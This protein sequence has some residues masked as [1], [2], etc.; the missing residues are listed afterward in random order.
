MDDQMMNQPGKTRE[1]MS[2]QPTSGSAYENPQANIETGSR[3]EITANVV[4]FS[5]KVGTINAQSVTVE[6]GGIGSVKGEN[7]TVNVKN[8]GVGA[9][10]ASKAD[11]SVQDGGVGSLMAREA[12]VKGGNI[13]IAMVGRISGDVRIG[14]DM[15][16]GLLAGIAA[17]LV[18]AAFRLITGRRR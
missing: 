9:V 13:A 8:G 11:V 4:H 2:G 7:A 16:A 6:G 5:G 18:M 15:R 10:M 14:F 1:P 17:G 12:T 3:E